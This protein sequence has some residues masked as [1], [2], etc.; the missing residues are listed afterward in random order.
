MMKI[1]RNGKE[2]E[3]TSEEIRR[4]NEEYELEC[5]VEDVK[6]LHKTEKYNEEQLKEIAKLISRNLSRNDSY[7]ESYWETVRYTLE[8]YNN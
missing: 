3:L 2:F 4:A 6:S 8:D 1:I 5:I 7:Y